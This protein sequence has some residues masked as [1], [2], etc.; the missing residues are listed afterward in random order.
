MQGVWPQVC[1]SFGKFRG[2]LI[3]TA[4]LICFFGGLFRTTYFRSGQ[5]RHQKRGFQFGHGVH[6]PFESFSDVQS[7]LP[8]YYP[9]GLFFVGLHLAN[10]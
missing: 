6:F 3:E 7:V 2:L 4:S 1:Q 8:I 5:N 10:G 9:P